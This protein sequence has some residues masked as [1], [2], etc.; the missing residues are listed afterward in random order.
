MAFGSD[1]SST[2]QN[3]TVSGL[4]NASL[5]SS[6]ISRVILCQKFGKTYIHH[7]CCWISRPGHERIRTTQLRPA[8][9]T[10][11]YRDK[12]RWT[13]VKAHQT[14]MCLCTTWPTTPSALSAMRPVEVPAPAASISI[15]T[16]V[17]FL[18][19]EYQT[20]TFLAIKDDEIQI[21]RTRLV[22]GWIFHPGWQV[23]FMI[24]SASADG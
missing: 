8:G 10:A 3:L 4:V 20:P 22:E 24:L 9:K 18:I 23:L 11:K 7:W 6:Q 16:H 2:M 17:S 21:H 14:S 1:F 15:S 12:S 5:D 19:L 13:R